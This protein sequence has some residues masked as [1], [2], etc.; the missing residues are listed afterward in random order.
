MG[1]FGIC[2][3]LEPI[4][5]GYLRMHCKINLYVRYYILWYKL[6]NCIFNAGQKKFKVG[7]PKV[8]NNLKKIRIGFEA[9]YFS[10]D[11][12]IKDRFKYL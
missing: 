11:F 9:L 5:W 1:D 8:N 4:P 3:V 7:S 6:K 10:V 12:S 2:R